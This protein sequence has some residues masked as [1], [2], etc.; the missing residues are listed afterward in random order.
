M[1]KLGLMVFIFTVIM[2]IGFLDSPIH[3][4]KESAL[5][6]FPNLSEEE[7]STNATNEQPSEENNQVY[8][9]ET[10]LVDIMEDDG[11]KVEVYREYEVYKDENGKLIETIPTENYQYLRYKQ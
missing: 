6:S 8:S 10:K 9:L 7:V 11:Y 3:F 2:I 5:A 4:E 1:K